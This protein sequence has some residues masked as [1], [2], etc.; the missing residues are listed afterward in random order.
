MKLDPN[1]VSFY[2]DWNEMV[3][4]KVAK[5]YK[6]FLRVKDKIFKEFGLSIMKLD[7]YGEVVESKD[8]KRATNKPFMGMSWEEIRDDFITPKL[9]GRK[10]NPQ[11]TR[12]M[13]TLSME[14]LSVLRFFELSFKGGN[15]FIDENCGENGEPTYIKV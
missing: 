14:N 5:L 9:T 11:A 2:S 1:S 15:P 4:Q 12:V 7:S 6:S 8:P 3:S 13:A 10:L